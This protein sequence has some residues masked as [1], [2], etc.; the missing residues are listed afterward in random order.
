MAYQQDLLLRLDL[1][2][3]RHADLLRNLAQQRL[4]NN[5][6]Q[7][8]RWAAI[9]KLWQERPSNEQ[10]VQPQCAEPVRL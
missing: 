4:L 9:A 10:V 2:Q 8:L 3:A 7:P 1:S 6:R 5:H